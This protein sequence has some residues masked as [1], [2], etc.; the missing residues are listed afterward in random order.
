MQ[1]FLSFCVSRN[2][3]HETA[4]AYNAAANGLA[5]ADFKQTKYL[6]QKKGSMGERYDRELCARRNTPRA[7]GF[8]PAM[9]IG[10]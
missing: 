2:I 5:E 6:L 9:L 4:S 7:D 1:F 10:I 3:E 8:S